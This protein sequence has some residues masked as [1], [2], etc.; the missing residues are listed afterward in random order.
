MCRLLYCC[1]IP[2]LPLSARA[3]YS[4]GLILA[5]I[6]ALLFK[7]HGLEWFPYRQTPECGM[8]CWNTLAVYRISFGLVI[9]HAFLMVFL[10]GVSDPSDP[11]IHVQNGL[12]PVKFVVFVGVMV[13]PFYMANHLFYQYWIACLIF[14]AM[15]V[16]LQSIILVDM[17]R[18]ISE[19]C[20]EMYDQT[21]S[22]LAKILLLSTTFICTTGFIAI[23]V[24]LYI[25]YGNCVLNR[26]FISVNLIMN[27]A[28]MG[29]SVVPKVLENHAKGGLL[30]SSV[31]A[32][33]NTFLVAVSAV[34]NPDHCQIGV[35]WASTANATKTSGDTAV[36][37]AGIAF[38][39]INIAY[40]AFSTSTMDIS[41][42]SSVAV[43]SDQGETI[44][45]NFSVFHLIFILTAFY[46]ASVFTNWSVFS[47]STVAGVDLSAVDKGVGPM[48]VSVATSW[49]NVL[50]YIWSLLAPIVFSN[51]DFS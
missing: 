6:L 16:I 19:H 3:Q 40:L 48:W 7:T 29:V 32:L 13:G 33:Y 51:R 30:P 8:A 37:V 11:R 2:P 14:S 41:G 20:I 21:Q 26:V 24:V 28:Q 4:I 10:I 50:L 1:C 35:V 31:L 42:K 45:Y 25:F 22:I 36:E 18:T 43:S 12:W 9:Y 39:V 38:L 46:M 17:A 49:I 5:C 27:L 23:T 34:S 15:F 44:E 47:I